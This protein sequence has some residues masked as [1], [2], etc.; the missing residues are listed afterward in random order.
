[1]AEK[2]NPVSQAIERMKQQKK[3]MEEQIERENKEKAQRE[4]EL[5]QRMKQQEE[6]KKK[7]KKEEKEKEKEEKAKIEK[8]TETEPEKEKITEKSKTE[9]QEGVQLKIQMK[10]LEVSPDKLQIFTIAKQLI[11][12]DPKKSINYNLLYSES[13]TIDKTNKQIQMFTDYIKP[14]VTFKR[15]KEISCPNCNQNIFVRRKVNNIDEFVCNKCKKEATGYFAFRIIKDSTNIILYKDMDNELDNSGIIPIIW[16]WSLYDYVKTWLFDGLPQSMAYYC[17]GEDK[18]NI[19]TKY[20]VI[21]N[22][23]QPR[24]RHKRLFEDLFRTISMLFSDNYDLILNIIKEN[25]QVIISE[26]K[27]KEFIQKSIK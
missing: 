25:P 5:R 6:E 20:G 14:L 2:I 8:K 21:Y 4:E 16:S 24:A 9:V 19:I 23:Q 15:A 10:N 7:K 1:M 27:L 26:E 3:E 11:N 22:I 18:S 17:K 13:E 12:K